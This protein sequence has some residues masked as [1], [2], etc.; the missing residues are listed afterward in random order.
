MSNQ[1]KSNIFPLHEHINIFK[2]CFTLT[3]KGQNF[4]VMTNMFTVSGMM[5][6]HGA[7]IYK[8]TDL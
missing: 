6:I 2:H 4:K 5:H 7:L 1:L 3:M 8:I